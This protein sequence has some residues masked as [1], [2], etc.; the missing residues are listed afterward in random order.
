MYLFLFLLCKFCFSN[1]TNKTIEKNFAYN[2]ERVK[3][4]IIHIKK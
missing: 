1:Y 2:L 3:L 4:Y